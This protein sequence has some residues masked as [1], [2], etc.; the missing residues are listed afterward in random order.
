MSTEKSISPT[1]EVSNVVLLNTFVILKKNC[2]VL[3]HSDVLVWEKEDSKKGKS[4]TLSI[5]F[6]IKDPQLKLIL[7]YLYRQNN[8]SNM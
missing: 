6:T 4:T 2:R 3:F 7:F 5:Q 1:N 8:Y